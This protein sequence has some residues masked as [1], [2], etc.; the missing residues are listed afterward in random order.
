M[1][2]QDQT[3]T[4]GPLYSFPEITCTAC[5]AHPLTP[6]HGTGRM[7]AACA[8]FHPSLQGVCE[9]CLQYSWPPATRTAAACRLD[10][11]LTGREG[12]GRYVDVTACSNRDRAPP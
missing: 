9:Q 1:T 8:S 6:P 3:S 2:P 7:R 4:S 10:P 5:A 12:R 11:A